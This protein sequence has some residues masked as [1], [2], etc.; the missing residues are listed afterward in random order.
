VHIH[1]AGMDAAELRARDHDVCWNQR[2]SACC[3]F[4]YEL[5]CWMS[6]GP[7]DSVFCDD[8]LYSVVSR[9]FCTA[10]ST[11][12]SDFLY[13]SVMAVSLWYFLDCGL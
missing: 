10:V 7:L 3:D 11:V 9:E 4:G 13:T 2:D 5:L 1:S 6:R 8:P 12:S